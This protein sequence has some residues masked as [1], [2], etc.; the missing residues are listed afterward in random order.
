[1]VIKITFQDIS[2]EIS[3]YFCLNYFFLS[4]NFLKLI[5]FFFHKNLSKKKIRQKF[6]TI[7]LMKSLRPLYHPSVRNFVPTYP[8]APECFKIKTQAN[9]LTFLKQVNVY[10]IHLYFFFKIFWKVYKNVCITIGKK[11]KF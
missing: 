7:F 4:Y 1:M 10:P 2:V 8:V 5:Q 6:F 9:W 3:G 11:Q